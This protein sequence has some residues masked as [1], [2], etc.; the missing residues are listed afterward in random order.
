MN[1]SGPPLRGTPR[2][3][4][5]DV[6]AALGLTKG[7]VSRALN[8]YPDIAEGTRVR[9]RGMADRMGYRPLG[10]A[11]AIRTGRC[12]AIGLVLETDEHDAHRP[13]LN[14]FLAGL[15][16]A[17]AAQSWTLTV[18]TAP[19][20]AARATYERLIEER[21]ADGFILP[22]TRIEDP[23]V[24]LLRN[25][26]VPFVLFGRHGT[27]EGCAWFDIEAGSA[28][29]SAAH[30]LAE[31]G[32][33]RI[34]YVGGHPDYTYNQVRQQGFLEGM[35]DM[36]LPVPDAYMHDGAI[37]RADG[38]RAAAALL[39]LAEPPTAI[40]YAIDNAAMGAYRAA[41]H[42]GK[43][44]GRDLAVI[45]YDGDPNGD[46][47]EPPLASWAVD[48]GRAGARLAEMLIAR[49]RG[50]PAEDLRETMPASFLDRGS[51]SVVIPTDPATAGADNPSQLGGDS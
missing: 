28:M 13:F 20:G 32:H 5:A 24:N 12:R 43:R 45:A 34:A 27:P 46:F 18:A 47:A 14:E 51:A 50:T 10:S 2:T 48:W 30:L 41:E 19:S 4:I 16:D 6:A 7:T 23:R 29:R 17:A 42:R 33:R 44:V 8:D 3:T 9:V 22:R 25:A 11:Q 31:R 26:G 21:K 39:D 35:D 15:S 37:T 49:V 40:V 38:E 36:G 1:E